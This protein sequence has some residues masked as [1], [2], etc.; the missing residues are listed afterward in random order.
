M[1]EIKTLADQ[2]RSR[3]AKPD[4]PEKTLKPNRKKEGKPAEIPLI[5]DRLRELD[6]SS[7]KTLIHAR[8]DEQ[9]AQMIHHLKIATG[10]EVTRLICF[11]IRQLFEQYPELK[12]IIK[13]HLE[14]F[15]I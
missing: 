5:I 2:L 6:V 13:N 14:K 10:V 4:T 1:S 8:V 15:E 7:N 11:S 12:T 9:T 3:M